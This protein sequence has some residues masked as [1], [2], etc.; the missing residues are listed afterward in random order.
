MPGVL[1]ARGTLG[2]EPLPPG[3]RT[4]AAD[5]L[6]AFRDWE[7]AEGRASVSLAGVIKTPSSL[8]AAPEHVRLG[9]VV[10]R[11]WIRIPRFQFC[12]LLCDLGEVSPSL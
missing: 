9:H 1:G 2:G 5:A 12:H 11:I 4:Q 6:A 8:D 3:E 10:P 7:G